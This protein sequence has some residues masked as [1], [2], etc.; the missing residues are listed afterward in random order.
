MAIQWPSKRRLVGTRVPRIDGPA[1]STGRAKYSYDVNL[2]G[3]LF[4]VIVRCPLPRAKI[5]SID[6][7]DAEKSKGF[8]ALLAI[9]K[10]GDECYYAGDE[11]IALCAETEEQAR[12]AARAVKI[13]Y[14]PLKSYVRIEEVLKLKE[15]PMTVPPIGP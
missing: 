10:V 9:K 1:K 8:K 7:K 11:V 2:P 4:G 6:T 15:D 3:M 14:D 12:D 13:E 5:K